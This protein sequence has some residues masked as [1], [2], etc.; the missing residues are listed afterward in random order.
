MRRAWLSLALCIGVAGPGVSPVSRADGIYVPPD[1]RNFEGVWLL[2]GDHSTVRTDDGRLPPMT[3][4][5]R[6]R[7]AAAVRAR[8]AGKPDF[9]TIQT[10]RPHGLPRILFAA[11]PIE[12][13]QEPRQVTFIHEVQHMPRMVYLG[14]ALPPLQDIDPNWMGLS[15]GRWDGDTLIVDS[16]G[17]NDLTTLDAA[18]L[19]H[20][21]QLRVAERIRK[22]DPDTLEDVITIVD[23]QTYLQP[24]STRVTLRRQPGARLKE[25]ACTESNPEAMVAPES[26]KG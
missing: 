18:G 1:A 15:V 16:E 4:E 5:A 2:Q 22:L 12:I 26:P 24:W 17:F 10:C 23:P 14:E 8:R 9:D 20:S 13:L 11:Y 25:Y 7:Y 6:A 19:P 3:R 21:T